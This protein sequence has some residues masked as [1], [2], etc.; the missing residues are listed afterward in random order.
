MKNDPFA[1]A[2]ARAISGCYAK[3]SFPTKPAA[4]KVADRTRR[5][6]KGVHLN[7]YKCSEC[8]DW[9]I[10]TPSLIKERK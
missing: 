5:R 2:Y 10:G 6:N 8:S 7:T 3:E 4:E 1:E 9:H